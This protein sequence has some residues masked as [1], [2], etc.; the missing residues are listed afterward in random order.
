MESIVWAFTVSQ[1]EA[2]FIA[3][4]LHK[5][6]KCINMY[7]ES[8]KEASEKMEKIIRGKTDGEIEI[9]LSSGE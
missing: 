4:S 1:V 9:H 7:A 8:M 2:I 6:N 3:N 5:H